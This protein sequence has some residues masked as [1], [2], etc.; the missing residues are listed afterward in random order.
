MFGDGKHVYGAENTVVQPTLF[1]LSNS[2]FPFNVLHRMKKNALPFI[3]R[4][5]QTTENIVYETQLLPARVLPSRFAG[6]QNMR[7]MEFYKA[8]EKGDKKAAHP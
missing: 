8:A 2:G 7:K 5:F 6:E 3:C 4:L 1:R